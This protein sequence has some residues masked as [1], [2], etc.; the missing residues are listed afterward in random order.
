MPC[1]CWLCNGPARMKL[2]AYVYRRPVAPE[3]QSTATAFWQRFSAR[4]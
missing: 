3:Q 1:R 2:V 4:G